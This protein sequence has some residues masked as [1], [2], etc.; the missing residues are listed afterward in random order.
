MVYLKST[1]SPSQKFQK[2][3]V[4]GLIPRINTVY[5]YIC[6]NKGKFLIS[7]LIYSQTLQIGHVNIR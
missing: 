3:K 6:K 2:Y 7:D 5:K 1:L 4:P